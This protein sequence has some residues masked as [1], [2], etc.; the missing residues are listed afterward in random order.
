[1]GREEECVQFPAGLSEMGNMDEI[2]RRC[3]V[4]AVAAYWFTDEIGLKMS[5]CGRTEKGTR[6]RLS[7]I[8]TL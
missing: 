3:K 7:L 1:M 6:I 2:P 8:P 5:F 4:A